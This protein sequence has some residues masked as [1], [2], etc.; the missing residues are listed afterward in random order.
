[1]VR[2]MTNSIKIFLNIAAP[3][4]MAAKGLSADEKLLLEILRS[5]QSHGLSPSEIIA[6]VAELLRPEVEEFAIPVSIFKN[7]YLGSLEAI[8]KYLREN[9]GLP[10]AKIASLT[11][12]DHKALAVTYRAARQKMPGPIKD[13]PSDF[14]IPVTILKARETSVLEHVVSYLK[15]NY[16]LRYHQVAVLIN[17]DDRTVWTVYQRAKRKKGG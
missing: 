13:A 12:R 16:S 3:C 4:L 9:R 10:F 6:K 11:N 8:V 17:R 7:D 15:D 1:M 14:F 2:K 5:L